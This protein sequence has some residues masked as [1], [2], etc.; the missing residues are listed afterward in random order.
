MYSSLVQLISEHQVGQHMWK[1][2]YHILESLWTQATNIFHLPSWSC[3][4]HLA[5]KEQYQSSKVQNQISLRAGDHPA[6][7]EFWKISEMWTGGLPSAGNCCWVTAW[8]SDYRL[9]QKAPNKSQILPK[10]E[11]REGGKAITLLWTGNGCRHNR[12]RQAAPMT[13]H[14]KF[15]KAQFWL[16]LC[17][18]SSP[19]LIFKEIT[20]I[21]GNYNDTLKVRLS[22]GDYSFR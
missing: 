20:E 10:G 16:S 8:V 3:I 19:V 17:P 7:K 13:M 4:S 11:K 12:G 15:A 22:L 9:G 1:K 5:T 2:N 6:I 14:V 21:L 18:P